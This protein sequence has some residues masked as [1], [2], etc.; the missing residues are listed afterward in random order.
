[1]RLANRDARR[2]LVVE[3]RDLSYGNG[4]VRRALAAGESA[5]CVIDAR[6]SFGWYDLEVRV[7]GYA[8]FSKRYAGRVETGAWSYSDPA[9]GRVRT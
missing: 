7:D 6:R 4:P 5:V 9:M 2:N 3:I 8:K 1:V